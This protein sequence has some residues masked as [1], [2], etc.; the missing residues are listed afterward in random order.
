MLF[1]TNNYRLLGNHLYWL[2]ISGY[3]YIKC[4][5]ATLVDERPH[6]RIGKG[7]FPSICSPGFRFSKAQS[8]P[9][10]LPFEN[11]NPCRE[12]ASYRNLTF[13]NWGMFVSDVLLQIFRY[14]IHELRIF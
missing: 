8:G 3:W 9:L 11:A 1:S 10:P 6:T 2:I 13:S 5:P 7:G 4:A 14:L 12:H